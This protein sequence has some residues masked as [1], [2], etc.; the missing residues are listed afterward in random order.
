ME[1]KSYMLDFE[2]L[3]ESAPNA[4]GLSRENLEPVVDSAE[5]RLYTFIMG[6]IFM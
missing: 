4:E 1:D 5:K 6:Y 3:A 2:A